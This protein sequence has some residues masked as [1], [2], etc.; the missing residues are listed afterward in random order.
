MA[1]YGRQTRGAALDIVWISGVSREAW[2]RLGANR[3]SVA[4]SPVLSISHRTSVTGLN[5]VILLIDIIGGGGRH[6]G[7][8]WA[9][10]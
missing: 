6:I 10:S 5:L 2:R 8:S 4:G 1:W 3:A 7:R 9:Y